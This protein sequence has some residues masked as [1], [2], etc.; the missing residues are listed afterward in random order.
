MK[1][2]HQPTEMRAHADRILRAG[3]EA[4]DPGTAVGR[5]CAREGSAL[6]I[7]SLGEPDRISGGLRL[8]AVGKA[9][10]GMAEAVVDAAPEGLV[11]GEGL[12]VT[13]HEAVRP[14]RGCRVLGAGHPLP[15]HAGSEAARRVN[16]VV[17]R[18]AADEVVLVLL[19]GGASA[20][21][22][23]PV[24]SVPL[25]D[26]VLTTTIL[27]EG[28]ATI[29][30]VNCVRKHLSAL[31]GGR[32]GLL[33]SPA[34]VH[35]LVL[36]DVVG[37]DLGVIGSGPTAPD[38][39]TFSDAIGVLHRIG[40]WERV[41]ASVRRHL[42][43]GER[44][45]VPET[46]GPGDPRLA[47][48]RHTIVGGNRTSLVAAR[49]EAVRLGYPAHIVDGAITGEA[50]RAAVRVVGDLQGTEVR[51]AC[52]LYGGETTVTVTGTGSGGRC[53]EMALAAALLAERERVAGNWV[54]A[55]MG[56]DGRDGPTDAAGGM[57]DHGTPARI[58]AAGADPDALLADNDSHRALRL[59]GDLIVTGPTGTNVADLMLALVDG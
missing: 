36:S 8:V 17:S 26:L 31:A 22:P 40:G 25:S 9:A 43:A 18:A 38:P 54:V 52:L 7:D 56:S 27:L 20:L 10:C 45:E 14:V 23:M 12:V 55:C 11:R 51:P 30:E 46:P 2:E 33:A 58:R 13:T 47:G 44:G 4:A 50:Q 35:T 53:Q 6:V 34:R 19:S 28:G 48:V 29:H 42:A 39:T 41:P 16:S 49:D 15:D 24:D 37:D 5:V 21:I 3:V 59:S 32:M 57:V 1:S